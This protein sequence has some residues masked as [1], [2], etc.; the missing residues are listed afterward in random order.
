MRSLLV[1]L[2]VL[3]G[4]LALWLWRNAAAMAIVALLY[5]VI[6]HRDT[7]LF[8]LTVIAFILELTRRSVL[9]ILSLKREG[10]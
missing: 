8:A 1:F 6:R 2:W 7:S 10:E 5:L 9:K 4:S 3:L